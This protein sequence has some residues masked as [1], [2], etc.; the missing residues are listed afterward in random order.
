MLF[1]RVDFYKR[2]HKNVSCAVHLKAPSVTLTTQ[3]QQPTHKRCFCIMVS[4]MQQPRELRNFKFYLCIPYGYEKKTTCL[5]KSFR[6]IFGPQ[7]FWV[8]GQITVLTQGGTL[9][10]NILYD[11]IKQRCA[12]NWKVTRTTTWLNW[13]NQCHSLLDIVS[14][15]LLSKLHNLTNLMLIKLYCSEKSG[16]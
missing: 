10:L 7:R 3:H 1:E 6:Y 13:T 14:S 4:H 15:H 2:L 5:T 9:Q 11:S 16:K 8:L 12:V